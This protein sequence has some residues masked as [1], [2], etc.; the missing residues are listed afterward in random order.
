VLTDGNIVGSLSLNVN[1][2]APEWSL[3]VVAENL[4]F[5]QVNVWKKQLLAGSLDL[6]LFLS[7]QGNSPK[8]VLSS[9][10]GNV[11]VLTSQLEV[12]S[13][14][15]SDLFSGSAQ[16]GASYQTMQDLF[17]KCGVI[18]ASIQDGEITFDN[19]AAFETNRF[20]MLLNG[21]INLEKEQINL[22]FIPQKNFN[23]IG[24]I[25]QPIKAV[26]LTGRL[27]SPKPGID[28]DVSSALAAILPKVVPNQNQSKK[29]VLDLYK[30]KTT[31]DDVS[32][33]RL[34]GSGLQFKSI[35][36][37]LGRE[38]KQQEVQEK[39]VVK[40]IKAEPTKAQKLGKELL[41]NFSDVLQDASA[42]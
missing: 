6:N 26:S 7:A 34:V 31:N 5:N 19:K 35:D 36:S 9:L 27:D 39:P 14:I 16:G 40:T 17:V 38:N 13:P 32:L 12:L 30:K 2:S 33:C 21:N 11:V 29:T 8:S 1:S 15:V 20:S 4:H 22:N 10:D 25:D 24:L 18:N 42:N 37:Y 23:R 28:L 41:E 3:D